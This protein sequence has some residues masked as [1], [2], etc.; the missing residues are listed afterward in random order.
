[1]SS[2]ILTRK[3]FKTNKK[4][5]L[6]NDGAFPWFKKIQ[7]P[8]LSTKDAPTLVSHPNETPRKRRHADFH[9]TSTQVNL[10]NKMTYLCRS[11]TM[12]MSVDNKNKV[13]VGIPATSRHTNIR[14]FH[15]LDHASNYHDH[16][17][18]NPNSKLVPAGYQILRHELKRSRSLSPLKRKREVH[19]RRCLSETRTPIEN[20]AAVWWIT[21]ATIPLPCYRKHECNACKSSVKPNKT[22]ANFKA[23][24]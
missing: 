6:W 4:N 21:S 23:N 20:K 2:G 7:T 13:K 22:K 5:L 14:T 12:A 17:F 1:M 19:W 24:C 16:D 9:Y 15:L 18:P 3:P 10:V 8:A 11:N